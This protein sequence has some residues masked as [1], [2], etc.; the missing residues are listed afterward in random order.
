MFVQSNQKQQKD[1][2]MNANLTNLEKQIIDNIK[3]VDNPQYFF[4]N[5]IVIGNTKQL[6]GAVASL[7]KKNILMIDDDKNSKGL[8]SVLD[9]S[10]FED[11]F[12]D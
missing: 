2:I 9:K 7:V 3:K 12:F 5:E 1:N 11:G 8:I 10:L 6:R 4:V